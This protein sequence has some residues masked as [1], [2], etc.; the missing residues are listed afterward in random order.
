MRACEG[1]RAPTGGKGDRG[2]PALL[3]RPDSRGPV[4]TQGPP[5]SEVLLAPTGVPG[6]KA[7]RA[8]LVTLAGMA[9]LGWT[10]SGRKA[11]ADPSVCVLPA[12]THVHASLRIQSLSCALLYAEV[13]QVPCTPEPK[14]MLIFLLQDPRDT[15]ASEAIL[16][17]TANQV[18]KDTS[19]CQERAVLLARR[20]HEE[21]GGLLATWESRG[22]AAGMAPQVEEVPQG[23]RV[24]RASR[25]RLERRGRWACK[26]PLAS[27]GRRAPRP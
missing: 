15:L 17:G 26:A 16:G 5:A 19:G 21:S 9:G 3:A 23:L 20:V 27:A 24:V 4:A 13:E 8:K 11:N 14:D 7:S 10:L 18:S 25:A 22:R 6:A 1:R 2:H 12:C